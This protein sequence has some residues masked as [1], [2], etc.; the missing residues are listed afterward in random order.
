GN[1][2]VEFLDSEENT[3]ASLTAYEIERFADKKEI[4]ARGN[5]KIESEDSIARGQY[6]TY[7]EES[8]KIILEGNPSLERGG[9]R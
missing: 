7:F 9:T 5:V 1:P 6:A 3:K 4:V 2:K 8:K